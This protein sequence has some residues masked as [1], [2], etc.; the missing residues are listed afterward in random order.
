[1]WNGKHAGFFLVRA[2]IATPNEETRSRQSAVQ[3]IDGGEQEY[4]MGVTSSSSAAARLPAGV[5]NLVEELGNDV[6]YEQG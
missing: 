5:N 2:R 6:Q 1:M 4:A 3:N